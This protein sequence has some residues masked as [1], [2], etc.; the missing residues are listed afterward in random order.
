M[1]LKPLFVL[2]AAVRNSGSQVIDE[3]GRPQSLSCTGLKKVICQD[4]EIVKPQEL[5]DD[6]RFAGPWTAEEEKAWK[7]GGPILEL[8]E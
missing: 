6:G 7:S 2:R 5:R 1:L 3:D 4:R 8:V